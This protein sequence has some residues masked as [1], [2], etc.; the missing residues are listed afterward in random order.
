MEKEKGRDP[1]TIIHSNINS[2]IHLP[3]VALL[4]S[5]IA[6]TYL[7]NFLYNTS[8]KGV[9][10]DNCVWV[11]VACSFCND[12]HEIISIKLD[13]NKFVRLLCYAKINPRK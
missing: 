8:M 7:V 9:W 4:L 11:G 6:F 3:S 5:P 13:F 1:F 12:G 10:D 2:P